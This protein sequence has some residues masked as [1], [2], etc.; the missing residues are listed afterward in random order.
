MIEGF[1]IGC[2]CGIVLGNAMAAILYISGHDK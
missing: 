1:I 2:L